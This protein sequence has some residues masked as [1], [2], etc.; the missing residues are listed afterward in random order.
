MPGNSTN[1]RSR[2]PV[3]E[4]RVESQN[5]PARR[6]RHPLRIA[7]IVVVVIL[8][9]GVVGFGALRYF[10]PA[11]VA[12]SYVNNLFAGKY[13]DAF[14]LICP[15]DQ[16]QAR[17]S[18]E[19][20]AAQPRSSVAIDT[21]HLTYTIQSES[22]SGATVSVAGSINAVGSP[23]TMGAVRYTVQLSALGSGWCINAT[24]LNLT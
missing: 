23:G 1:E 8:L 12:R 6:Q 15:S 7:L 5:A 18:F 21:S 3:E 9:L 11:Q 14:A 2:I 4:A 22:L 17:M 20:A 13:S 10:A 19:Q 24:R 16:S